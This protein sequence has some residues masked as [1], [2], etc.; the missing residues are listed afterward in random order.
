VQS[1]VHISE[2]IGVYSKYYDLWLLIEETTAFLEEGISDSCHYYFCKP[3][4]EEKQFIQN[5]YAFNVGKYL[6]R[7]K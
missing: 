2:Y 6:I 3:G 4:Y 7:E 5:P 1:D